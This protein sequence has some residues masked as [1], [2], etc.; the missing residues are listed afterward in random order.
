[1]LHPHSNLQH[2]SYNIVLSL[3]RMANDD[4]VWNETNDDDFEMDEH[5]SLRHFWENTIFSLRK[6]WNIFITYP[7]IPFITLAVMAFLLSVSTVTIVKLN[8]QHRNMKV[9]KG[10]DVARE[11]GLWFR[12]QLD[13]AIFPLFA[14]AELVKE[15]P[16]FHELPFIIGR[17]GEP[18]SAPYI[19]GTNGTAITHRNVTGICD[20]VTLMEAFNKIGKTVKDDANMDG[21]LTTVN[22]APAG[23]V[24]LFYPFNNTEDFQPPNFLDSTGARGHDLVKDPK[25]IGTVIETLPS[26]IPVTSGPRTLV[27]CKGCPTAVRVAF[28]AMLPIKM[29]PE[30]G[31]NITADGKSYSVY[32]FTS[33][34]INWERLLNQSDIFYRFENNGME[35]ELSKTDLILNATTNRYDAQVS[36]I[37]FAFSKISFFL[38]LVLKSSITFSFSLWHQDYCSC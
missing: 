17:G 31:Y 16:I 7:I 20:N 38:N 3:S 22:I 10:Q 23:V 13:K 27:Q 11:T 15:I 8:E 9:S 26:S 24:C 4:S 19:N 33:A 18:G 2:L 37:I 1:M 32:G 36:N 25:R 28:I 12:K 34:I 21:V 5:F 35:F 6:S 14:L 29:P 30:M